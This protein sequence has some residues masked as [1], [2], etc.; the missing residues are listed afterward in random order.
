[1]EEAKEIQEIDVNSPEFRERDLEVTEAN[2]KVIDFMEQV[3][4]IREK[5]RKNLLGRILT[6]VDATYTGEARVKAIK[7]MI[8]DAF[9][10]FDELENRVCGDEWNRLV[11]ALVDEEDRLTMAD[12]E[13]GKSDNQLP[14]LA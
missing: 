8:H 3:R 13:C 10:S 5:N 1:M 9:K 7:D 4:E 11:E 6:I 12:C 2:G 14:S